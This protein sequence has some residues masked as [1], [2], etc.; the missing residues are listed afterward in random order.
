MGTIVGKWEGE[1]KDLFRERGKIPSAEAGSLLLSSFA[2]LL[3][4]VVAGGSPAPGRKRP[5]QSR[6]QSEEQ[7]FL[8]RAQ[9]NAR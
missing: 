3:S 2:Q 1:A 9:R 8:N 5:L 7:Q 4:V 6:M